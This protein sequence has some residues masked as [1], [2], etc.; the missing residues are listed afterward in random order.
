MAGVVSDT[1]PLIA[2]HQVGRLSLLQS[3]FTEVRVPPAVAREAAPSL[4]EL[5][6]WIVVQP[7]T[8]PIASEIV[9]TILGRGE[10][11]ALGLA[12]EV[13]AD[14]VILDERPARRLALGLSVPVVGTVG[15]LVRA[16]QAGFIPAVRP[17]VE[18]LLEL[19]FRLSPA[20][21]DRVLRDA[22]EQ[23]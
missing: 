13:N 7:L 2:L 14:L 3:L 9:Q 1:S 12:L 11:E 8:Q 15:I 19:G 5:P 21:R 4:P 23:E 17:L 22:G 18:R 10:S 16:K 20:M 6:S